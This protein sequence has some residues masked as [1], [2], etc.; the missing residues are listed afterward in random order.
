MRFQKDVN[1]LQIF[2]IS[3]AE[4]PWYHEHCYGNTN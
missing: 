4:Q 2:L 3:L 1:I